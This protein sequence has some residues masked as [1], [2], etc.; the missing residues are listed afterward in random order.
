[1][2]RC[3]VFNFILSHV[4]KKRGCLAFQGTPASS[5]ADR[6]TTVVNM[7][8]IKCIWHTC[9]D[10]AHYPRSFFLSI[11][12][13]FPRPSLSPSPSLNRPSGGVSGGGVDGREGEGEGETAR[14]LGLG[15]WG[16][17]TGWSTC[18]ENPLIPSEP[19]RSLGP[20]VSL[21]SRPRPVVRSTFPVSLMKI[22]QDRW[23]G[24][25]KPIW[26]GHAWLSQQPQNLLRS[27]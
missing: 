7:E 19:R 13:S 6:P 2:F 16:H 27:L 26:K 5:L 11:L 1:M 23:R 12:P 20:P 14:R 24:R 8:C 10:C 3:Y 15:W 9:R 25:M 17:N 21:C 18:A 4:N 22:G